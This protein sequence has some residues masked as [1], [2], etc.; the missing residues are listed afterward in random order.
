MERRG[1]IELKAILQKL[2]E[3][4]ENYLGYLNEVAMGAPPKEVPDK[5]DELAL[6]DMLQL[7]GLPLCAGG[8][9]DQ[10]HLWM[11]QYEIV[12]G[13]VSRF[14]AQDEME[15]K[16]EEQQQLTALLARIKK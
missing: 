4:T 9:Q 13:L 8:Y 11:L 12:H 2:R 1:G 3:D 15:K 14:K 7:T 6:Y 10:P 5:P 16:R